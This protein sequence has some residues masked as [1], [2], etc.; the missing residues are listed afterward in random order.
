MWS[1]SVV[2]SSEASIF[3]QNGEEWM[4]SV[5]Q[6]SHFNFFMATER[7][8]FHAI[9]Q[10]AYSCSAHHQ[11]LKIFFLA[12]SFKWRVNRNLIQFR[13][14]FY[15]YLI[16][17]TVQLMGE[18]VVSFL[19]QLGQH[20]TPTINTGQHQTLLAKIV[21]VKPVTSADFFDLLIG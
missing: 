8:G 3:G 11:L 2:L 10:H 1:S 21:L 7:N 13:R 5:H 4:A 18:I 9:R 12:K 6:Y 15:Q 17:T 14:G 20:I 19:Q 16:L